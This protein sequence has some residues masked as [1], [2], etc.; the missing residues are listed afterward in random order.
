MQEA[1]E[2]LGGGA[3]GRSGANEV[4]SDTGEPVMGPAVTAPGRFDWGRRS[5]EE[6]AVT[7]REG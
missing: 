7:R 3:V 4:S 5:S 1:R 6:S 2:A